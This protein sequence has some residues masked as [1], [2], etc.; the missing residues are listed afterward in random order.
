[1]LGYDDAAVLSFQAVYDLGEPRN[2]LICR[3]QIVL[4]QRS[5]RVVTFIAF[6]RRR[7]V[8]RFT[9]RFRGDAR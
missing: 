9:S 7:L 4:P 5:D 8:R 3:R 1:M 6:P 2:I